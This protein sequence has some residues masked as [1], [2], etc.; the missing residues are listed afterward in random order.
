MALIT[1]RRGASQMRKGTKKRI[2]NAG[3]AILLRA[4]PMVASI[5]MSCSPQADAEVECDRHNETTTHISEAEGEVSGI[6]ILRTPDG[7]MSSE[8]ARSVGITHSIST[9][10]LPEDVTFTNLGEECLVNP[11]T[12]Y[13]ATAYAI[14]PYNRDSR[15]GDYGIYT[16]LY[17]LT[18]DDFSMITHEIGHLQ[19]DCG[20]FGAEVNAAE[21]MLMLFVAYS[22][23]ENSRRDGNRWAAQATNQ[24]YGLEA[25]YDALRH[26]YQD[27]FRLDPDPITSMQMHPKWKYIKADIY[28]YESLIRHDGDFLAVRQEMETLGRS[29]LQLDAQSSVESF[30]G[31][32]SGSEMYEALGEIVA[33]LRMAHYRELAR[34]FGT[35]TARRYFDSNSHEA[36]W[37]SEPRSAIRVIGLEG[38]NCLVTHVAEEGEGADCDGGCAQFG[39]SRLIE[40]EGTHLA[41]FT[42]DGASP[43]QFQSWQ[44]TADGRRYVGSGS[45]GIVIGGT[46]FRS[47]VV[48]DSI[49][50]DPVE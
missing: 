18:L 28:I 34:R 24:L 1:E 12:G 45:G 8:L 33:N 7:L 41:C 29:E 44:V 15:D 10:G 6:D 3:R 4:L 36:Y 22:R 43:P 37:L 39:A 50:M 42:V 30:V 9:E 11:E 27:N 47:A 48:F 14:T 5:M 13:V 21:Q 32:Y 40:I 16:H 35:E 23:Q 2:L 25:L 46:R 49:A 19:T 26:I 20:E 38:M 17:G 31:R